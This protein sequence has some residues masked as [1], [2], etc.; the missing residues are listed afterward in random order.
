[1]IQTAAES[2]NETG[3]NGQFGS[4]LRK[5]KEVNEYFDYD[6]FTYLDKKDRRMRFNNAK[7]PIHYVFNVIDGRPMKAI[8]KE[9]VKDS[10]NDICNFVSSVVG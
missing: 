7:D 9:F 5:Q 2:H 3:G 8:A 6:D 4:L 10:F 1:M